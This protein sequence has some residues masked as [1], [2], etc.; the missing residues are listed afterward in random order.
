M[1]FDLFDTFK[2]VPNSTYMKKNTVKI[3][4]HTYIKTIQ[5]SLFSKFYTFLNCNAKSRYWD[6]YS[7]PIA[8][9][10]TTLLIII[11]CTA[12]YNQNIFPPKF[13][14]TSARHFIPAKRLSDRSRELPTSRV[15]RNSIFGLFVIIVYKVVYIRSGQK[16]FRIVHTK[17][18]YFL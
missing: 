4:S 18:K 17:E 14:I 2:N 16:Y 10:L 11:H 6:T 5:I 13:D 9:F 12:H 8:I 15:A 3:K 1:K 7:L